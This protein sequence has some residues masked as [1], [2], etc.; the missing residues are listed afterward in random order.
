MTVSR[1]DLYDLFIYWLTS[2]VRTIVWQYPAATF[3]TSLSIGLP[4][5]WGR[6]YDSI[7]PPPLWPLYLLAY[8]CSEDDCMTVS[9]RHLCDLF[10]YWL[11]SAVRTIVWQYPAATLV[12]S[13]SDRADIFLGI[14]LSSTEPSPSCPCTPHPQLYTLQEK[15]NRAVTKTKLMQMFI[16]YSLCTYS[17]PSL[18]VFYRTKNTE[19]KCNGHMLFLQS[20]PQSLM[21]GLLRFIS[22]WTQKKGTSIPISLIGYKITH[23]KP[24]HC[25]IKN[26]ILY[27][28]F[29]KLDQWPLV[30]FI[31]SWKCLFTNVSSNTNKQM[32]SVNIAH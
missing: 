23:Q 25:Y 16:Q 27:F 15:Q 17:G 18:T 14:R 19:I 26:F 32:V 31:L 13:L 4:V 22:H 3:M 10:I 8:Q 12:T 6:L 7:P 28:T 24:L 20:G 29:S 9:R 1:R 2:A 5:Q 21:R 30:C 11:T